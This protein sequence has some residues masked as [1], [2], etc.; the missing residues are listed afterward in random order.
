MQYLASNK[1]TSVQSVL[2]NLVYENEKDEL[3]IGRLN[4]LQR[5]Q[6]HRMLFKKQITKSLIIPQQESVVV[7]LEEPNLAF[8]D[9]TIQAVNMVA[10]VEKATFNV[11]HLLKLNKSEIGNCI[12]FSQHEPV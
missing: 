7:L 12:Q 11:Q 9:E 4:G 6:M 8:V 5:L 1:I 3:V 10:L 2:D